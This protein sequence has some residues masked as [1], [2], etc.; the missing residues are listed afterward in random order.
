M[1][2][3]GVD[4]NAQNK[5][6]S[7]PLHFA[8]MQKNPKVA[9]ALIKHGALVDIKD[10]KGNTPLWRAVQN[11]RGEEPMLECIKVLIQFEANPDISNNFGHSP[12]S[13]VLSR[14]KS[15]TNTMKPK[16]WDLQPHLNW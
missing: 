10:D 14:H 2:E 15:M 8:V 16:E 1:V 13:V 9:E 5:E 12:R 7:A 3:N 6:L 4:I 11:Y